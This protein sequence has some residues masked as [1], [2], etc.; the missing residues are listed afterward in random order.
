MKGGVL[1]ITRMVLAFFCVPGLLWLSFLSDVA[2]SVKEGADHEQTLL[3][4]DH[5]PSHQSAQRE[6]PFEYASEDPEVAYSLFMHHSS[7]GIVLMLGVFLL[8]NRLS[9]FRNDFL[10]VAISCTWILL[11]TFVFINGDPEGWPVGP[12]G[13][14]GSFDMPTTSEWIQHK[15]LSL[16]PIVMGVYAFLCRNVL[17][18]IVWKYVPVGIALVGW[19]LLLVHQHADHPGFDVVNIQHRIFGLTILV[20]AVGLMVEQWKYVVWKS[21]SLLVPFGVLLL[22]LQLVLYVE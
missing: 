5:S 10:T 18:S 16:I 8:F 9:L 17:P 14:I 20:I 7:G 12:A 11:G 4:S 13:F 1:K 3:A 19:I 21:K 15:L 2:A 22:G 6:T